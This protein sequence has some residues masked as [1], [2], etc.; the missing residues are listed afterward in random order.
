MKT[1]AKLNLRSYICSVLYHAC[2]IVIKTSGER[3]RP[4]AF[5]HYAMSPWPEMLDSTLLFIYSK[6]LFE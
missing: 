3:V 2:T 1:F 4:I 5:A 6:A